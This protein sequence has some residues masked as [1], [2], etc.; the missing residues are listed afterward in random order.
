LSNV[1]ADATAE[2]SFLRL[3][4]LRG[5]Y[6]GH[7]MPDMIRAKMGELRTHLR[8]YSRP[9]AIALTLPQ[10]TGLAYGK[11]WPEPRAADLTVFTGHEQYE[12]AALTLVLG[13]IIFA[14]IAAIMLVRTRTAAAE[15]EAAAREQITAHKSEVDRVHALLLSEPQ[16][17]IT[18][19]AADQDDAEIIGDPSIIT[20]TS[21]S[22]SVLAF[23]TWLE[24]D[25]ARALDRAVEGLRARGEAFTMSLVTKRGHH[26]EAS[27]RAIGG[28]AMLRLRDMSGV[29]RELAEITARHQRLQSDVD[30]LRVLIEALPAPI[31]TR[32]A[33]GRLIFA[34]AAYA[35]AVDAAN[36]ADAVVRGIELLDRSAREELNRSRVSSGVIARRLPA[37]VAGQRRTLDVFSVPIPR[38]S[39]A[40]GIDMTE[41]DTMRSELVRMNEAHRRTLDQL[42]TGVAIFGADQKLTFYN[43]A[44]SALWDINAAFLDQRPT[45]SAILDHLRLANKL[46][47]Q[48]D[49]RQWRKQL[50]EAYRAVEAKQHEWHLPDGRTL[51]VVTTPNTEGG[52][53]YLFDDVTERLDLERRFDSLIRVQ[54][55]TL[56]NLA[57]AVAV[58]GSDGRVRLF[59][60]VFAQMWKLNAALLRER[61]HIETVIRWCRPLHDDD[62]TWQALRSAVTGLDARVPM[63]RRLE[64][65]DGSVLDCSTLPLPDGATLVTFQNVTDSVNVERALRERNQALIAADELKLDFVHHVSYELRSPLTNIIGFAHFLGDASTG[66][67]TPRQR[68]YLGYINVSTNALLAIINN[69]LDLATIDAGAMTL[70]LGAV[71]IRQTMEAAA[72]GVQDRL[73]KNGLSLEIRAA[74]DI[75]NFVADERRIRQILFNLLSNAVGFSPPGETVTLSAERH[76]DAVVFSVTDRGP[77][78][79]M[80]MKDR[81]FDWFQT[82]SRGSHHRGAGLG[83][84]IVRSFVELHGGTVKIDSA[85]GRGTTVICLFP[86]DH[87]AERTAAE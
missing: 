58:F 75:G 44:Y 4:H 68:E 14:L 81:V 50:H 18:W 5:F 42:S 54:G 70:N 77:G 25:Q 29:E 82:D 15:A 65:R 10:M 20:S 3:H 66:P 83:L 23:A 85:A 64:R 60:P 49:F 26:V 53:T 51:R 69:I 80:D 31:W 8:H 59:N 19:V 73:V 11:D 86:L 30:A 1:V 46:P 32:D 56:D 13:I 76:R 62:L 21:V 79:P 12:I 16:V 24:T 57:E 43:A 84:S 78:I 33:S 47:E 28:K 22:N 41:A 34:N 7:G 6:M 67:L 9:L 35:R 55:E 71:D 36:G 27:G 17:L 38:G 2:A 48:Q 87:A 63:T 40:I 72:E 39:V 74:P 45:D 37:I 61:P 52:A